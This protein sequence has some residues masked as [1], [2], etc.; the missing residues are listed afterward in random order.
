[1]EEVMLFYTRTKTPDAILREGFRD[2]GTDRSLAS[3]GVWVSD[4]PVDPYLGA[5]GSSVLEVDAPEPEI[6]RYEWPREE[7]QVVEQKPCRR[8]MVPAK[9]LNLYPRRVLTETEIDAVA[10]EGWRARWEQIEA[11]GWA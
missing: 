1:L 7:W 3:H 2:H 4:Q 6:R 8:F 5:R 11:K 9:V 10:G